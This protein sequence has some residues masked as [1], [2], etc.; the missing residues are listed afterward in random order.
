M[1]LKPQLKDIKIVG[2]YL[3]KMI[4]GIAFFM[5]FPIII[6]LIAGEQNP[7]LDFTI[8]FF[9]CV[10]IG[11]I[12]YIFCYTKEDPKWSHGM[13]VISFSW[14][15]AS[16]IGAIPLYLSGHW[17]SFLDAVFDSMSGF[18]TSGLTLAQDLAHMSYGHQLWRH[19]IMFI[20]GQGIVVVVLSFFMRGASGAFRLYAGE[21]RDERILPDIR[22]TA[23]FIWIV[24]IVYL[25][26]GTLILGL[27]AFFE[28]M[29]LW[30]GFFHG[31]CV[32]MAAFDTGGFAPQQQNIMY[33]H[34]LPFEIA[35]L[36]IMLLGAINFKLH[37]TVWSG[38]RKEIWRNIETRTLLIVIGLMFILVAVGLA[39]SGLYGS[40]M[41]MF[42]KG[43]YHL[44]SAQTGTG[45]QVVYSNQFP[46]EWNHL[47]L[48]GLILAMSL[49]GSICSTTGA[50]KMLRIGIIAKSFVVD[51]KRYI[52]PELAV[53][54]EKLHHI[55]KLILTETQ[56]RS[57]CLITI[58]Y[59]VMYITG[60][61]IGMLY[62]YPFVDSLFES[63]SAAANVGLSC[64]ITSPA[65]PAGLKITYIIQMW[66]G[67]LEFISV[68]VFIGYI[69]A[70]IKGK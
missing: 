12:L 54:V 57:A 61:I 31:A 19:L 22:Q 66:A 9:I 65:M 56:M 33:Y 18:T 27:I 44:I 20:G 51:V 1:I 48:A 40:R 8:S 32:F 52:S 41:A 34:S 15:L 63:T 45:F 39:K 24:S 28:G 17:N 46:L 5:M 42:R 49:G 26:L 11:L 62:G 6:S 43:F 14:V 47:S 70:F 35:T 21:A 2:F 53:I 68:F 60:A 67:R 50:I 13:T 38:N 36:V 16:I 37:Y 55:K 58:A 59:I 4:F 29:P 25:V 10:L 64:G 30:K 69:V 23:R 3:G 7:L